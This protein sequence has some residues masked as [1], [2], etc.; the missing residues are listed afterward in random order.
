[1]IN[2][3]PLEAKESIF[4]ARRNIRL[5]HWTISLLAG[6]VGILGIVGIGHL[7]L[8]NS[9]NVYAAQVSQG[10]EELKAQNLEETQTKVQDLTNNLKL[11]AQ[12]LQ[13]EVLFSK[14]LS[15]IGAALPS[16]SVLTSLSINKVQGGIDLQAAATDYQTATQVQI[17]MHDPNN[18][19]F[20]K[21]DILSIQC[22]TA[23]TTEGDP[24]KAQ[25]PCTVQIRALFAKNNS[26]SFIAPASE[27]AKP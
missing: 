24:L 19:I 25:Y 21:A 3:L 17:N 16:G 2:L 12:V 13:R 20:E 26:F 7:Y 22:A 1:M 4:Y 8:H 15:Q 18:K 11:V 9:I 10:N 6:M 27:S 14:L 23:T 5:R